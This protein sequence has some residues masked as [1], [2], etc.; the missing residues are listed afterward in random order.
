MSIFEL[1]GP[2]GIRLRCRVARTHRQRLRGVIGRGRLGPDEALLLPGAT[3]V[4]T[5]G[6][7]HPLLVARLDA[8]LR[9]VDVRTVRPRR[10]LA[11]R[12]RARHVLEC[13]ERVDLRA[14]D[15]LRRVPADSP[16]EAAVDLSR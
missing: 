4:H 11:P 14:G 6:L 15:V 8:G 13:S 12:W 10:L 5:F 16:G 2:R 7:R 1:R 3:S 9:V